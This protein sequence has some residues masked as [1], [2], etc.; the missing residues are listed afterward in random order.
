MNTQVKPAQTR[1]RDPLLTEF[2][3]KH[4]TMRNRIISTSHA[5]TAG[6]GGYPREQYQ[7]YHEEKAKGGLAMTMIG[8]SSQV[9]PDSNWG[10]NQM[11]VSHDDAIPYLQQMSD[12]VHKHGANIMCQISHLGRRA[13]ATVGHWLPAQ[14]P[15]RMREMRH[16]AIAHEMDEHDIH[17]IIRD[18]TQAARRLKEGG[19]DGLETLAG[20]HL[21]GQ[22]FSPLTNHR[23]DKWG[24]S[25]QN[26]VRFALELHDSIRAEVGDDFVVGMRYVV[27]EGDNI[28]LSFDECVEIAT[29]LQAETSI[30]FFN[31]IFGKMDTG[32]ALVE[33][34][35]PNMAQPSAP[36]LKIVGEFKKH[37]KL[38]VFHAARIADLET[39]RYAIS[40]GL[41]DLVGMTR[42]HIADPYIVQKLEQGEADRIRPCIGTSHCLYRL[43]NCIHNASSNRE[44]K[45]PHI[46]PPAPVKKKAVVVGGGPAGLESARVLAER[47]H[48]VVLFEAGP[49]VGGQILLAQLAGWR[50]DL[51]AIVDWREAEL[52]HLGVTVRT[53]VFAGD[54]EIA[55]ENPDVVIMATGGLPDTTVPEGGEDLVKSTWDALNEPQTVGKRVLV[56]D[57]TGRHQG[58][59]TALTLAELGHEVTLTTMDEFMAQEMEYQSRV[60]Y[61]KKLAAL[62]AKVEIDL[63]IMKV[64]REGNGLKATMMHMLTGER[65]TYDVDDVIVDHGSLPFDELY[66]DMRGQSVNNG[67]THLDQL[68]ALEPQPQQPEEPGKGYVMYNIGDAVASRSIHAAIYDAFRLC[69]VI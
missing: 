56:V 44:F 67:E 14:G 65:F 32:K 35:I 3:L 62:H 33:H 16:R 25:V 38:P 43:G 7:A 5:A 9:S 1:T 45:L 69:L 55:A 8:G 61:R 59:S 6:G 46:V 10:G 58:P 4:L 66:Q 53:N 15:S 28:G 22:F 19:F 29:I 21:I 47:G 34:N 51:I 68:L 36:F 20:G 23:T 39:A 48:E 63:E 41:L 31:C 26:R 52:E 24:G 12:R 17:R 2:K 50:R 49:K 64:E 42:A 11:D 13:D 30:D 54:E 40:E 60:T 57:G 27:D 37:V 18:Y